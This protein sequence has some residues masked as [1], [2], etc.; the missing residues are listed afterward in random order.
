MPSNAEHETGEVCKEMKREFLLW[1]HE[2]E[3]VFA[4][5]G[6]QTLKPGRGGH[7]LKDPPVAAAAV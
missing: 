2:I 3:G 5:A 6:T 1:R 7:W 4:A